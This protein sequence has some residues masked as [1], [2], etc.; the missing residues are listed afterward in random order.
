MCQ[1]GRGTMVKAV[2]NAAPMYQ[3]S[4]YKIP[5]TLINKL[6]TLQSKFFWGYK[7]NRGHNRIAWSHLCFPKELGGLDFRDLE[8]LNHALL[9]KMAWRVCMQSDLLCVKILKAKYFK[10]EE[11][12][13]IQS[14]RKTSSWIWKDI[15]IGVKYLQHYTCMEVKNGRKTRNWQ[16]NWTIGLDSKPISSCPNHLSYVYVSEII[17]PNSSNWNVSLLQIL[18][19]DEVVEKISRM[20]INIYEEDIVRWKPTKDGNFTVKSAYNK[21]VETRF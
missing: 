14:D 1:A 15:E 4:T 11:F 5:K 10:D 7:T 9:I 13:H 17:T 19:E 21:L 12:I 18:F 8:M 3:M 2:L 16:D 20:H 6:D